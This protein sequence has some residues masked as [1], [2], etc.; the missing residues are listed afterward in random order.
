[1]EPTI[2]EVARRAGVSTA[3]VSR[4][5]RGRD[6][7]SPGT[8]QRVRDVAEQMGYAASP[9]ASRLASGRAGTVAVVLP[10]LDRWF[11]GEILGAA[12]PAFREAGLDLLLYH[13]GDAETRREYFSFGLLRKRVDG[14]LLV[15][16]AL[17]AREIEAL[18]ALEVPVGTVGV[19]VEG[20]YCVSIDDVEAAKNAVQHLVNLG[21]VR[22]ALIA[23]DTED[24][25]M[26]TVPRDRRAGYRAALKAAGLPLDPSL[27][28]QG[29]FTAIGGARAAGEL[30]G[31]PNPPTAI[32]AESDEMAVGALST[33]SRLG[34][35]VPEDVSVVGFDDHPLA[36]IFDLTTVSQAVADQ[37]RAVAGH[38]VGA[39]GGSIAH[40]G[41]GQL[42]VPTRL[43]VRGSAA[44][45]S[46]PRRPQHVLTGAQDRT[47]QA[48]R[49][50]T[51]TT[52]TEH[53]SARPGAR[54]RPITEE[55][56]DISRRSNRKE[57][58]AETL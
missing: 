23:G 21:H 32:F 38:L 51:Q 8:A 25:S 15:T 5:L 42:R 54:V 19:D 36:D 33:L 40:P 35:R 26:F 34:L 11:F 16:L 43:V 56:Q 2:E 27:E 55:R 22:I 41:P 49:K 58:K 45:A 50:R 39:L 24:V 37:G 7:V 10:Y 20:F 47:K 29:D 18:R 9:F 31:R 28:V 48:T 53:V 52:A 14:V 13:V 30:F 57:R 4:S 1:V 12:E 46:R 3:T 17:T 6:G 44:V